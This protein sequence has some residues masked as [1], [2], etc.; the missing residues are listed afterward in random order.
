MTADLSASGRDGLG[1]SALPGSLRDRR[2]LVAAFFFAVAELLAGA[3]F[4]AVTCSAT[5]F[6]A[7]GFL[8]VAFFVGE[9]WVLPATAFSAKAEARGPRKP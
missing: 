1:P 8:V 3:F 5:V 7:G 6:V 9:V 2:C 4:V